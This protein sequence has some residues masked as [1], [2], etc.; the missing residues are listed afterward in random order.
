[1]GAIIGQRVAL[2][3]RRHPFQH[4]NKCV[5]PIGMARIGAGIGEI[6]LARRVC[7]MSSLCCTMFATPPGA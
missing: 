2:A 4:A 7:V 6:P 1:M 3:A 5:N